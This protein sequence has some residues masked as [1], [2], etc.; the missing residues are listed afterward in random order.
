MNRQLTAVSLP[1]PRYSAVSVRPT[2]QQL[3]QRQSLFPLAIWQVSVGY[4]HNP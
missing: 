1:F 4:N 3:A 2:C